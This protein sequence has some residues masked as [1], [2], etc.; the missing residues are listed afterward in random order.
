MDSRIDGRDEKPC[1]P[2]FKDQFTGSAFTLPRDLVT[3]RHRGYAVLR[4]GSIFQRILNLD[5]VAAQSAKPLGQFE[6]R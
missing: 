5:L 4:Y 2:E 3:Y 1:V 6:P